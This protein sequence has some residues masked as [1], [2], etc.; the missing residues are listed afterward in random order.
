MHHQSS[1]YCIALHYNL[2][3]CSAL[4]CIEERCRALR[5]SFVPL[6]CNFK[7]RTP[8]AS[9]SPII[10]PIVGC[11]PPNP[12]RGLSRTSPGPHP[13]LSELSPCRAF[14]TLRPDPKGSV[15]QERCKGSTHFMLYNTRGLPQ[16]VWRTPH[17]HKTAD[18]RGPLCICIKS[19][20]WLI[21]A[22]L[23]RGLSRNLA[24]L[25]LMQ[26]I[27]CFAVPFLVLR[28]L[29]RPTVP[30]SAVMEFGR[31]LVANLITTRHVG[32]LSLV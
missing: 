2:L 31:E 1:N 22:G 21:Y 16:A 5:L 25:V 23:L 28:R 10:S 14:R 15:G 26:S 29:C 13:N 12:L 3:Q 24:G 27:V 8:Y 20:T 32:T 11:A 4:Q 17:A 7:S 18:P 19:H 9:I 6:S 30:F